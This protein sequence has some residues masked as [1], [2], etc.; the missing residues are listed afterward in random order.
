VLENDGEVWCWRMMEKTGDKEERNML[1]KT[2]RR[3]GKCTGHIL[4]NNCLLKRVIEGK[5]EGMIEVTRKRGRRRQQLLKTLKESRNLKCT[6]V[7]ALRL[8]TG[9]TAHKGSRGIALLYRH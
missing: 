4:R 9:R 1:H 8:C 5:I 7:Q 6:L 3:K 2:K